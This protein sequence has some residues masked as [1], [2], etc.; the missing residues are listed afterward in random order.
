[1]NTFMKNSSTFFAL[2]EKD[3]RFIFSNIKGRIIDCLSPITG[4]ILTFGYL[5]PL[6]GVLPA[7]AGP[8][9]IGSLTA[10]LMQVGFS[11]LMRMLIDMENDRYIDYLITLPLPKNWLLAE[12]IMSTALEF[13][14]I[15]VP[16]LF[17]SLL[18]LPIHFEIKIIPFIMIMSCIVIFFA[19]LFLAFSFNFSFEYAADNLWPRYLVPLSWLSA[20]LFIWYQLYAFSPTIA[21]FF[22]LNPITYVA[23][24][25]RASLLPG[26]QYINVY[27]CMA[28]LII[29]IIINVIFIKRG[30]ENKLDPV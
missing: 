1:M 25:L 28:M 5:F 18:F 15:I 8:M 24:G 2:L 27:Y 26:T 19:S 3:I 6:M 14:V 16:L 23:E 13:I 21:Y 7:K 12:F 17:A 9:F 10:L 4:Q 22:L 20:G 29:F 30:F 11:I